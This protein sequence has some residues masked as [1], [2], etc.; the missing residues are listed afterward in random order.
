[1][2]AIW[3]RPGK[4]N[5]FMNISMHVDKDYTNEEKHEIINDAISGMYEQLQGNATNVCTYNSHLWSENLLSDTLERYLKRPINAKWK[6]FIEGKLER[7]ITRA[8]SLALRSSTSPFYYLYRR[9]GQS[10]RELLDE[11]EGG[12]EYNVAED[13]FDL[14]RK[15]LWEDMGQ[16]LNKLDYYDR[17]FIQK[18]YYEGLTLLEISKLV[19]I[20]SST[21]GLTIKR[22]LK[23]LKPLLENRIND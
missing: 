9:E 12:Y 20:P 23:K 10:Y 19:D 1:M 11:S 21:I 15:Q 13:R 2:C 18:Y 17:F 16:Y 14:D 7:Y 6:I 22:A 8:M 4:K 5:G 3:Y